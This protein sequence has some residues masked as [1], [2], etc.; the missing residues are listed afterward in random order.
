MVLVD[1]T[2]LSL[3][4]ETAGGVMTNII[5]RNTVVPTTKSQVFNT[6]AD[7]QPGVNIQGFEGE[8]P[9]TRDNNK[10]GDF[11][12]EGIQPAPRG[13]PQIEVSFSLDQNGILNVTAVDKASKSK[14]NITIKYEKG[15]LTTEEIEKILKEAEKFKVKIFQARPNFTL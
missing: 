15:R 9:L 8:R 6:F 14:N 1:V 11:A 3:G 13:V 2:P 10:L 12:L 7:N 5:P 4:I